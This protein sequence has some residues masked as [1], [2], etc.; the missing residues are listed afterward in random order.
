MRDFLESDWKKLDALR[1]TTLD[2]YYNRI[3]DR[4]QATLDRRK[5]EDARQIYMDTFRPV[6]EE[7]SFISSFFD[8]WSRS[9]A[10]IMFL[11]WVNHGLMTRTEYDVFSD[12]LKATIMQ[13]D[14]VVFYVENGD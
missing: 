6:K 11:A 7:R 9:N 14:E 4:V 8:H 12:D 5:K 1:S 10:P 13:L 2:R 3:L